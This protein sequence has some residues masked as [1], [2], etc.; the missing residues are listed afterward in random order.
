MIIGIGMDL[1]E[2]GRVEDLL[3]RHPE[4]ACRKLFTPAEVG[5]C[6]GSRVPGESFAARFAAQEAFFKAVGTGWGRGGSWTEVEVVSSVEGVPSLRLSG[7]ARRIADE[8][9]VARVHL[10][11]THTHE[12]AGAYVI[13]EGR[14]PRSE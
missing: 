4:R 3:A 11:L 1:V 14:A 12:L 9:G 8:L 2:V 6:R 5:R 13:L 7:G 10:T